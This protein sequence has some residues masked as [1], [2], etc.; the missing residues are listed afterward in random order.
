[1]RWSEQTIPERVSTM[2][3]HYERIAEELYPDGVPMQAYKTDQARHELYQQYI[4]FAGQLGRILKR[5]I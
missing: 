4:T 3:R 5:D 1:M 2:Q